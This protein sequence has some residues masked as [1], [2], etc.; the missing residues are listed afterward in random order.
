MSSAHTRVSLFAR[1]MSFPA[2]IAATAGSIPAMPTI[3]GKKKI[4]FFG[5]RKRPGCPSF[6]PV[7]LCLRI[8][9]RADS[10]IRGFFSSNTA[11]TR[12]EFPDLFF[13]QINP[14]ERAATAFHTDV[15][16]LLRTTSSVCVPTDPV[17]PS[18]EIFFMKLTSSFERSAENYRKKINCEK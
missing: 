9:S 12:P 14:L 11:A 10:Q 2:R 3:A 8:S 7:Y 1:A 15:L 18:M 5:K 16:P 4:R 17:E 6:P 13:Q